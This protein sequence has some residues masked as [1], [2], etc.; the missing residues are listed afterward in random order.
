MMNASMDVT[1]QTSFLTFAIQK[2]ICWIDFS[3]FE[4]LNNLPLPFQLLSVSNA[5]QRLTQAHHRPVSGHIQDTPFQEI[6]TISLPVLK[7]I[8]VWLHAAKG[9]FSTRRIL[10]AKSFKQITSI[11]F[12]CIHCYF[13]FDALQLFLF[14]LN[15][16]YN[17]INKSV[18]DDRKFHHIAAPV[19]FAMNKQ[20]WTQF[21]PSFYLPNLK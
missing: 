21:V 5:R 6:K 7:D 8:H 15:R 10:L 20:Q 18:T 17:K 12:C 9:P 3:Q 13:I 11:H 4:S 2:V 16:F 1:G 14:Y 19:E